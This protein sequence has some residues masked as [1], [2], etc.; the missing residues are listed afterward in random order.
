MPDIMSKT[1]AMTDA[2]TANAVR[3]LDISLQILQLKEERELLYLQWNDLSKDLKDQNESIW[4]EYIYFG[5]EL[6]R[7]HN[8][9]E[10]DNPEWQ[11]SGSNV[12]RRKKPKSIKL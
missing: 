4:V 5:E 10:A 2:L 11:I 1:R 7:A 6:S 12:R 3:Q 9:W 8:R